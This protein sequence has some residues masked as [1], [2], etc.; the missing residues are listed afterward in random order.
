MYKELK[1]PYNVVNNMDIR[2]V[3]DKMEAYRDIQNMKYGDKDKDNTPNYL[4]EV[5]DYD[6]YID[7]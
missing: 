4:K 2:E 1:L 6:S 7:F 5:P 3:N